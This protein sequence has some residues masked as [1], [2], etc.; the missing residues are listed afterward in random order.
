MRSTVAERFTPRKEAGS[1][2]FE[3]PNAPGKQGDSAVEA[4]YKRTE[5]RIK[6]AYSS[7]GRAADF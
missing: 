5:S 4:D 7:V 2:S 3:A 6:W 1:R